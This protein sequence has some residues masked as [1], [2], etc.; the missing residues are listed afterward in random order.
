MTKRSDFLL[1]GEDFS[2]LQ[3]YQLMERSLITVPV[4]ASWDY[5]ARLMT[6]RGFSCLPVV[7]GEMHLMGMVHEDDLIKALLEHADVDAVA[8]QSLMQETPSV[9]VESGV[10]EVMGLLE[11]KGYYPIPVVENGKLM[12]LVARRDVLTAYLHAR[13]EIHSL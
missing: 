6:D 10:D 8:A 1:G 5:L 2:K 7:D 4:S 13:S 3:A 11:N 12:G 9:S